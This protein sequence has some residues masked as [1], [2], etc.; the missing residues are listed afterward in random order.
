[1]NFHIMHLY[2]NKEILDYEI[3]CNPFYSLL[4]LFLK[5]IITT[6]IFHNKY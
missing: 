4:F 2:I 3:L 5:I 1:M 6:L